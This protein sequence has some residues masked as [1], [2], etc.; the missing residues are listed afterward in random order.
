MPLINSI[1]NSK[2]FQKGQLDIF[3]LKIPNNFHHVRY[4]CKIISINSYF[5]IKKIKLYLPETTK[6]S[7]HIR[8][9]E[10]QDRSTM[11]TF[12]FPIEKW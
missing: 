1:N 8:Y 2:P 5:K 6:D 7:L 11:N 4:I 10:L 9:C 3:H 12:Y